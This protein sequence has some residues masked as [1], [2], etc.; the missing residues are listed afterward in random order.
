MNKKILTESDL[1]ARNNNRWNMV[2]HTFFI[3][4]IVLSIA[5]AC[6]IV[7]L[8]QRAMAAINAD[9]NSRIINTK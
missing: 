9:Q 2:L 1:E 7:A 4:L 3:G 8:T 5:Q 6:G